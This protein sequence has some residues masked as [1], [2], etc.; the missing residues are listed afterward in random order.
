MESTTFIHYLE[1]ATRM[2]FLATAICNIKHEDGS[3]EAVAVERHLPGDREFYRDAM[4]C[5]FFKRA[6]ERGL[7]LKTIPFG[8]DKIM[9]LDIRQLYDIG[10]TV[11]RD[12][13]KVLLCDR[14]DCPFCSAYR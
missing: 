8:M 12:D 9:V 7:E 14:P 13:P 6:F 3:L 4:N 10:M 5:K 1:D 2:P 11:I